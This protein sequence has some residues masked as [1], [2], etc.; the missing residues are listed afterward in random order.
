MNNIQL[1][2]ELDSSGAVRSINTLNNALAKTTKEGVSGFKRMSAAMS[3]YVGFL[4]AM[5]TTRAFSAISNGLSEA[6]R[7]SIAYEKSIAEINTLL[8]K[9]EKLTKKTTNAILDLAGAYGKDANEQAKAYYQIVSA[10]VKGTAEQL[11]FLAVANEAAIAGLTDTATAADVLTS[12]VNAYAS[13]GLTAKQAS[14]ALF[15][16]VREGKTTFGELASSIG[17]VAP[18][19]Q[20]AG[21]SFNELAGATAYL[22]KSG[23]KTEN[24]VTGLKAILTAVIKP[25]KDAA[26]AAK[27]LGIDFST[28]A[29][30]AKGFT[31]FL[32]E[33]ADKTG[34]SEKALSKLIPNVRGLG[35]ILN[36]VNGDMQDFNRIM[37]ETKKAAGATNEAYK[38]MANTAGQKLA[39]QTQK[40][41]NELMGLT[42]EVI[43][44]MVIGFRGA[45]KVVTKFFALF[46]NTNTETE[47]E[48][49]SRLT[50]ESKYLAEQL[51][52][53]QR[54]YKAQSENASTWWGK[55]VGNPKEAAKKVNDIRG[56]LVTVQNELVEIQKKK[57]AEALAVKQEANAKTLEEE[58]KKQEALL[59]AK[60]EAAAKEAEAKLEAK[61]LEFDLLA[62]LDAA[63][64][65]VELDAKEM[66]VLALNNADNERLKYLQDMLGKET[67]LKEL[68]RIKDI[69]SEEKRKNALMKLSIKAKEQEK[70]SLLDL[71]K[72]EDMTNKQKVEAQKQTL[73]T[74][75]T[76]SQSNNT[77]LFLIGKAASLALA[78]INVAEGVTKALAAYPPPWNFAAAAAVG[79][80]GAIQIG[81]IASQPKPSFAEGG[82][83]EGGSYVND[84]LTANVNAGEMV[85][86]KRQQTNLFNSINSGG[87]SGGGGTTI[88][89]NGDILGDDGTIDKII[90][91][92]NDAIE[93][94]NKQLVTA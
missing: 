89:I 94:R 26:E 20:S 72:F 51:K 49:I 90:D 60:K 5:A 85:L 48:K 22:T 80:A 54:D 35:P 92:I 42:D 67:A 36:I 27:L 25:S 65:Q 74:I 82:I 30:K 39:V 40:L 88:N 64:K 59:A 44:P 9:H 33:L 18:I 93:L 50:R 10:G 87:T 11:N 23:L 86:N 68:A 13:S 57:E 84:R 8:P 29:I 53:A 55:I 63:N 12:S 81:K 3:S 83:V 46:K 15:I 75:A 34:G 56:K 43:V 7:A 28:S 41:K 17:F 71:R 52:I 6:V 91:G 62:E 61:Q 76:L 37:G 31:G 45:V 14:D 78:G 58:K 4:G 2:I 69:K 79:A 77:A 16:A 32:K 24:A 66:Q 73:Q 47:A 19:A 1:S 21:V 38:I 70:A